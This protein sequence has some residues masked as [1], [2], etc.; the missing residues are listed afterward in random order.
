MTNNQPARSNG[1]VKRF[2]KSVRMSYVV[3]LELKLIDLVEL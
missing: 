2:Q 3:S 1:F